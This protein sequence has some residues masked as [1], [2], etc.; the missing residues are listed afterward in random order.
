MPLLPPWSELKQQN[1][2]NSGVH[3]GLST[4]AHITQTRTH[5][6]GHLSSETPP[7]VHLHLTFV[8]GQLCLNHCGASPLDLG[9]YCWT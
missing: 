7:S 4:F 6:K 2:I 3:H 9:C 1:E 8:Y 5:Q